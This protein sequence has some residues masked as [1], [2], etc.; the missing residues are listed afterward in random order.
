MGWNR[1]DWGSLIAELREAAEELP[2]EDLTVEDAFEVLSVL[3]SVT[4][5]RIADRKPS[6][7]LV[8]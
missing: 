6:L 4:R 8:T 3:R 5:R 7:H 1:Q 2:V